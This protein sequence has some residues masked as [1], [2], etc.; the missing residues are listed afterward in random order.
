M[1][2]IPNSSL[3][4]GPP[5]LPHDDAYAVCWMRAAVTDVGDDDAKKYRRVFDA[6]H[7]TVMS[8]LL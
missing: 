1:S 8:M 4:D 3:A 5:E 2:P 6:R 7:L